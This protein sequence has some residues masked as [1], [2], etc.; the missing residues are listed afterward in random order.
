MVLFSGSGDFL[1]T[2]LFE[3]NYSA[4]DV[5]S[6]AVS[7]VR[8]LFKFF[9]LDFTPLKVC[10]DTVLESFLWAAFIS[11]AIS[12]LSVEQTPGHAL[13]LHADDMPHPSQLDFE[14][15]GLNAGRL[16]AL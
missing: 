1:S 6:P 12:K 15:Y 16:G 5:I 13:V 11:L 7:V 4:V 2:S 10:L 8:T 3:G 14:E 9:W